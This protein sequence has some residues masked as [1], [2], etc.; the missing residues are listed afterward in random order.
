M[1]KWNG[2]Q[3]QENKVSRT[4]GSVEWFKTLIGSTDWKKYRT[5]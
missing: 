5:G 4:R 1:M 2:Y 3:F